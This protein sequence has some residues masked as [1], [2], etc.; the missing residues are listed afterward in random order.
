MTT[1]LTGRITAYAAGLD[2]AT[3]CGPE[4]EDD[5][6]RAALAAAADHELL[7][8]VAARPLELGSLCELRT[9]V[10]GA[11]ALADSVLAVHGLGSCVVLRGAGP[12][13]REA[14]TPRLTDGKA[15]LAFAISEDGAGSDVGAIATTAARDG[16]DWVLSGAKRWISN[17]GVADAYVVFARTDDADRRAGLDAF[18][19]E[20]D[21]DGV[22]IE[23]EHLL[24]PH[25]IGRLVLD[26]AR[27][28]DA[29][30]L[31]PRFDGCAGPD[32]I[33]LAGEAGPGNGAGWALAMGTLERFR[34][35]VGAAAL[36]LGLRAL[37]D[38]RDHALEREQFG[39][40]LARLSTVAQALA[41]AWTDLEAARGL[42]NAAVQ[43]HE[44]RAA[45][46]SLD[47]RSRAAGSMAKWY[48]TEAA[49]RAVDA[50]VQVMGARGVLSGGRMEALYREVRALR[51]Y[52]GASEI[53]GL[54]VARELMDQEGHR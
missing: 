16:D 53:Q 1:D 6:A 54:L 18:L 32:G 50:C 27:V 25:P 51:I 9:A 29:A 8:V 44:R 10:A 14:W 37:G 34:P 20:A 33:E 23:R 17:A 4:A 26:G 45:G 22:H 13:L 31:D 12:D 7:E 21:T 2:G 43:A 35:S 3:P 38:A 15:C 24:A 46:G 28:Q 48:A 19:V 5:A 40:P 41:T 52:E 39:K 36:G 47:A 30:R 49:Q 11:S 42:V